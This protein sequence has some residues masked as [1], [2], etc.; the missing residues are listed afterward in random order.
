M[1]L[2]RPTD[3]WRPTRFNPLSAAPVSDWR[4][5]YWI[6]VVN[7]VCIIVRSIFRTIESAQGCVDR[8]RSGLLL[9]F[10]S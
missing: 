7:C 10:P 9:T 4:L 3:P 6:L 2:V 8:L 1:H 5:L